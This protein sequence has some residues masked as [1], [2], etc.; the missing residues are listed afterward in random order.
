MK[1][2]ETIERQCCDFQKDLKA[3]KGIPSKG[4]KNFMVYSPLFC[5]HCGQI[6]VN[7]RCTGE[8]DSGY[9]KAYPDWEV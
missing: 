9:E 2:T 3:Y 8:M 7:Y 1:I 6:W 5:I 4:L